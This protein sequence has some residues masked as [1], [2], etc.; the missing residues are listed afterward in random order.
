MH[1]SGD[2]MDEDQLA[3]QLA[4]ACSRSEVQVEALSALRA[5]FPGCKLLRQG[6]EAGREA[7]LSLPLGGAGSRCAAEPAD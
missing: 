6:G 7:S 2:G 1:S 3:Q 5:T 4:A